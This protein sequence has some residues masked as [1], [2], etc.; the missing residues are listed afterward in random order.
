MQQS[1]K[2]ILFFSSF[3]EYCN[4]IINLM[5]KK[6]IKQ[7]FMMV[8]VDNKKYSIP[9]FV[10]RVPILFTKNDEVIS[11]DTIINYIESLYPT[12]TIDI[13][14][15]SL[16]QTNYSNQFSFLEETHDLQNKGYTM[17][18]YDQKITA[19]VETDDSSNKSKF[20]SS[21]LDKYL[22]SRDMDEQNFK[23]IMNSGNGTAFNRL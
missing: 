23:K 5:I 19:P 10:D 9:S 6:N 12:E 2:D 14:P 1:R 22:Q 20:D 21:M 17:L 7:N 13:L 4:D 8:C 16:Q 18:G 3:C 11:D 15:Y